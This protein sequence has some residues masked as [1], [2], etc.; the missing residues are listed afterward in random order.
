MAFCHSSLHHLLW[1]KSLHGKKPIIYT[2][3]HAETGIER[4]KTKTGVNWKQSGKHTHTE[5]NSA[6]CRAKGQTGPDQNCHGLP[7]S[8]CVGDLSTLHSTESRSADLR[9]CLCS[10]RKDPTILPFS[11]MAHNWPNF[12]CQHRKLWALASS[13]LPCLPSCLFVISVWR[14]TPSGTLSA[15]IITGQS[16]F[17]WHEIGN[18]RAER[19]RIRDNDRCPGFTEVTKR[20]VADVVGLL[21]WQNWQV[22]RLLLSLVCNESDANAALSVSFFFLS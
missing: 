13:P 9:V 8:K 16:D 15:D 17:C 14:S 19:M 3:L 10:R 20:G 11:D 18:F 5:G 2:R 6:G 21:S 22:L 7:D 4:F 1:N 12:L